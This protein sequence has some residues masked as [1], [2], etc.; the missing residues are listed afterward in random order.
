M[1]DKLIDYWASTPGAGGAFPAFLASAPV[2]MEV[3]A[4]DGTILAVSYFWAAFLGHTPDEMLGRPGTAFLGEGQTTWTPRF[5]A[6]GHCHDVPLD[7]RRKDGTIV[8][9]LFSATKISDAEGRHL[10]SVAILFDNSRAK[11]VERELVR[12]ARAAEEASRAKSRFLAAMSHEIRTPMNAIMGFAQLLRLSSLDAKRTSHVDAILKAGGV[13]M[14]LLTDLLDLSHLEEGRMRIDAR[15]IDLFVLIDQIADWWHSS[16]QNKGLKLSV[17][18]D[19]ALPRFVR[20]DP[21][22][23]Q[24]VL[25]NFLGNAVKFTETGHVALK[26]DQVARDGDAT[27]LRFEVED[28]GPGMTPD[29]IDRLFKPF[30]QIETDFGKDRGGWGLGLSICANIA[31]RLDAEIGVTST[32]GEGSVFFFEVTLPLAPTAA[33]DR[34]EPVPPQKR[35]TRPLSVLL[36]EDDI[37]N[38]AMMRD[39]LEGLGHKVTI[40]SN[41]FQAVEAAMRT[42]YD[43]IL[44][45]VM[46]PG[47]D[48]VSAAE[49]IRA[50][51][52]PMCDVPIIACSAHVGDEA[53]EKYARVGMHDFLPKP[54]DRHRLEAALDRV[55]RAAG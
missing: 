3:L 32:P 11:A 31:R 4:P 52:A 26:V 49:Q 37:L 38:Q 42:P 23:L 21:T 5:D 10:H 44:M 17:T 28:T 36:A 29:Q 55:A 8:P 48:G 51:E 15:P 54:I 1:P 47:M 20:A 35:A 46:M 41:G 16:A 9:M 50:G 6:S 22:R 18:V 45:D 27:R 30:V 39:F 34:A 14:N 13:L 2:F 12:T 7:A 40:A 43:L 25:N 33:P 19:R 24:Q 53:Q